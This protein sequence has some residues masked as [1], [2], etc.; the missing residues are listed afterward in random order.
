MADAKM[1]ELLRCLRELTVRFCERY[2]DF[3]VKGPIETAFLTAPPELIKY[4][5][6]VANGGPNGR[7]GWRELIEERSLRKALVYGIISRVLQV[8]VIAS[9]YFAADAKLINKLDSMEKSQVEKDGTDLLSMLY[10]ALYYAREILTESQ[11]FTAPQLAPQSSEPGK[12]RTIST[13]WNR[14][15]CASQCK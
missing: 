3:N 4:V 15:S 5:G 2:F 6:C 9:L 13:A 12:R 8:H 7:E 14:Q 11:A 10:M 1:F